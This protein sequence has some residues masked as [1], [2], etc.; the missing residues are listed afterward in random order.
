[1]NTSEVLHVL[2]ERLNKPLAD[3]R[4]LGEVTLSV[5]M[6]TLGDD[7]SFT[8]PGF[9]TFGSRHREQRKLYS[10]HHQQHVLLP[11]KQVVFFKPSKALQA[12]ISEAANQ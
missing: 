2:A 6:R 7:H 10:P 3:V 11:E 5:F 1:M 12:K 4:K 9:G 8:I